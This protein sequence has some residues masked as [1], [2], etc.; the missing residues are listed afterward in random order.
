M[1]AAA[2]WSHQTLAR[3]KA[4]VRESMARAA[5][6][7]ANPDFDNIEARFADQL[8]ELETTKMASSDLEKSHKVLRA[9]S[10]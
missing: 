1:G 7:L 8:V 5:R 3:L 10:R 9:P 2:W 4:Q 6:E